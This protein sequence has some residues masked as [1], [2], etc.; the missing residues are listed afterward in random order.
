M[1][2]P[3][4]T[5][6]RRADL[7]SAA[8]ALLAAHHGARPLVLANC[9]DVASARVV[10]AAG[11]PAVATSSHAIADVLGGRDD[12][13]ADPD[14]L[15][16]F[17]ARIA[18]AVSLPVTADLERGYRLSPT[19][20]VARMLDAGIVGCNLEDSDHHGAGVLIEADRQADFLAAVRE[21]SDAAG[22]HIVI[23]ARIDTLIR[24]VGDV[25][26]QVDEAIRRATRYLAAGADCVYPITL[27]DPARIR[28][29]ATAVSAPVNILARPGGP[30]IGELSAI[31]VR[32]VSLGAGLH[33]QALDHVRSVVETIATEAGVASR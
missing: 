4:P 20:L 1:H 16:P 11:F 33:R 27:A 22:V 12:D 3:P 17:L 18:G 9:W 24:Q 30:T 8:K 31:G 5:S 14:V 7:A 6:S 19:E 15:F 23:N 2:T 13:T 29:F 21:A 32:R 26:E 28:Q 25:D 10:E